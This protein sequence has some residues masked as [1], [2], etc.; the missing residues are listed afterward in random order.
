MWSEPS[1]FELLNLDS[2]YLEVNYPER[3]NYLALFRFGLSQEVRVERRKVLSFPVLF[4]D[5]L[6]MKEFFTVF[7]GFVLSRYNETMHKLRQV[8]EL[9]R[10]P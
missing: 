4:G 5:A 9:Y 3:K 2:D 7:L 10:L 6:G 1:K 8:S